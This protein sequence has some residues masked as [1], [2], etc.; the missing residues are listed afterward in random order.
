MKISFDQ[1]NTNQNVDKTATSYRN[2]HIAGKAGVSGYALDIS[3]TVMDNNAYKGQGKTTEEVMQDAQA[4]DV[5]TQR[6]YM[7]V[8]SNSMSGEDFSR[9]QREGYQ[10]GKMDIEEVV[11]IVDQIKAQLLKGGTRVVGYT[12]SLDEETMEAITG[13]AAFAQELTKQF[14]AHDI[15]LTEENVTAAKQAYDKAMVMKQPQDGAVR[16][17]VENQMEPTI[18]NLYR[19]DYSSTADGGKQGYGYYAQDNGAYYAKKA[20]EY[21]WEQLKPQMEKV[22][23]QADLTCTEENM[24]EARWLVEMGIPL[25]AETLSRLH[26]IRQVELPQSPEQ[27]MAAIASAISDGKQPGSAQLADG[28]SSYEKAADYLDRVQAISDE[29]VDQTVTE[30]KA[31]T[32][33]NLEQAQERI[34]KQGI[35]ENTPAQITARRQLEEVRLQMTIEANRKL[36]ESGYSI[37]TTELEQLVEALKQIETEQNRVLF[38][39]TE[40]TQAKA[41][42]LTETN[43]KLAWIPQL[44]AAVLTRYVSEE[45]VFTLDSVYEEGTALKKSYEAARESYETLMTTPRSDMGDSIRKAFRNVDDILTGMGLELSEENRKAVRILGYS[46]MDITDDNIDAVKKYDM[47]LRETIRKM[48]PAATLQAIREGINPLTM[49]MEELNHYLDTL[50]DKNNAREEKFSKYLYKLEKNKAIESQEREAYIGIYRMFRQLEKTDDAAVGKLLEEGSTLSFRNLLTAMR[51]TK[52]QGMEYNV[53][54]SFGGVDAVQT[55]ESITDQIAKGFSGYQ[56]SIAGRI[57]DMM[58][59]EQ[60]QQMNLTP[61]M[62]L[63]GFLDELE[64]TAVDEQLEQD[65]SREQIKE[66]QTFH[67]VEDTVIRE[68]LDYGQ[69]ITADNL[70]AAAV[71]LKQGLSLSGKGEAAKQEK[72]TWQEK[73]LTEELISHLTD[74]EEAQSAY[75]K[76]E[77]TVQERVEEAIQ[78]EPLTYVDLKGLQSLQKQLSLAG[79]L[80]KEENY[81]IP[82]EINGEA[83][84]INLKVLHGAQGGKVSALINTAAYGQIAAQFRI[85]NGMVSGYVACE[86][87]EGT[88]KM[89]E[90][91]KLFQ[92]IFTEQIQESNTGVKLGDIAVVE[93]KETNAAGYTKEDLT[94]DAGVATADLYQVAKAFII[95][96]TA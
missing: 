10:P 68:L 28:R 96:V 37:D 65:Y 54:D 81:H 36:L 90:S 48:T 32:L 93:S 43:R 73:T 50:A 55:G 58:E 14:A 23:E 64:Q 39:T 91:Q 38:G 30:G 15:P 70:L 2:T 92:D 47:E 21:H 95:A 52:K 44:P 45:E 19:A 71:L 27:V 80:A 6:D 87:T 33:S 82:V 18:D 61:D 22:L 57:A 20:E 34:E 59:P 42:L 46:S 88:A 29:A 94:G 76:M 63:E 4:I 25:T 24:Q 74:T 72:T 60:L 69:P 1:I 83:A 35:T 56:A 53:D 79:N 17:M 78:N 86:T 5:A 13:S 3:G 31:L 75:E 16:Y 11:T 84:A 67:Q 7:T 62:S 9:L 89:Q 41:D 12:D 26:E 51:S 85:K 66:Y 77:S 40:D 8:M 49:S